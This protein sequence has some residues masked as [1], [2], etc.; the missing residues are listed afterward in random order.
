MATGSKPFQL[1]RVDRAKLKTSLYLALAGL[2]ASIAP[3]LMAGLDTNTAIG[4]AIAAGVPFA[5]NFVRKLIAD[6]TGRQ[7]PDF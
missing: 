4:G 2:L 3:V 5:L 1:D 7:T 6:N